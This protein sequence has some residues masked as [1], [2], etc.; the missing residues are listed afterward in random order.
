MAACNTGCC[1]RRPSC[2]TGRV[3]SPRTRGGAAVIRR[4]VGFALHQPLFLLLVT[5]VFVGAGVAS[6]RALPIEAFPDVTDVQVTVISLYPGQ[7]A[8]EVERQVTI[9]LEIAVSGLPNS[10]R[11]FAHTQF[12]LSFLI[13]TFDDGTDDYFARQQVIERL[14]TVSLPEGVEPQ[15]VPLSTPIG[16][17]YRYRLRGPKRS[18]TELRSLQD[19]VVS[20]QLRMVPGVAEVVTR[21]GFV[22]QYQVSLDLPKLRAHGIELKE[23][24]E[25]LSRSNA[26]TGGSYMEQGEQQLLI[27]GLGMIGSTADIENTV[28]TEHGGT[29]VFIRDVATVGITAMPR[30][31]FAAIDGDSETV[32]GLVSMR[33]GVNPTEVLEGIKER[34]RL[35]NDSVLPKDVR[36]EAFY[37]RQD[38]INTTLQTVFHNLGLGA[39]LVGIVLYVFLGSL[40]LAGIV[41]LIIPLALLGTFIGLKIRGISAN[42]LSLGALDFGILI[43]GAVIVAENIH[44]RLSEPHKHRDPE[45][46]RNA[47]LEATVQVGRPT[48]FSMVIIIVAHLPIFTLQRHEGRIFEPMAYT[49]VSALVGALL[50]SLTLI[51]LLSYLLL[52]KG[53]GEHDTFIVRLLQRLYRPALQ[54]AFQWPKLVIACAVVAFGASLAIVPQ[55]GSEFLPELDEG[56]LWVGAVLS[57]SVS[58]TESQRIAGEVRSILRTFPEVRSV[59]AQAGRPEDGTDPKSINMLEFLVDLKPKAQWGRPITKEH[60]IEDMDK[61]VRTIPSV[62]ANFSQYI[63]DNVLE[64]I[65]QIDG[66]IVIKIYGADLA[67]LRQKSQEVLQQVSGVDGVAYAALDRVGAVPQLQIRVD[68]QRAARH[69]LNIED[70]QDIIEM[71]LRGK[72]ATE[73]WEGESRY[74]LIVR[75]PEQERQ[76]VETIRT[77]LVDTPSG[78]RVP[79]DEVADISIRDGSLNISRENGSRLV[80]VSVFLRG[81]DM[82][83]V[84]ADMQQRVRDRV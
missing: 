33:K 13:I 68:R 35:L 14:R 43:D 57:P 26:N 54:R 62:N 41:T 79:L 64:S 42:L 17:I 10:V 25:A 47:I 44:R 52:R 3:A 34:V 51:P 70:V 84:V 82:G 2:V 60:L 30:Q 20:R 16:E 46:V 75:L 11:V 59:Y 4:I 80:A 32:V 72:V 78:R 63:R 73:V 7:A 22:K 29:P 12:G 15:L 58:L 40:R 24:F 18:L 55:L 71:A 65:S 48:F 66:Q 21:G 77:I 53:V 9:P 6:F 50:F 69:G 76:R 83:S 81:R 39:L 23:L 38:L 49:M 36:I 61:S 56:N 31:G 45:T 1:G 28:V 8:E 37:D 74:E 67:T 5:A 19:W 27:R